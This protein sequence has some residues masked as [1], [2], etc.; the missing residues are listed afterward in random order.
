MLRNK[1]SEYKQ[2]LIYKLETMEQTNPKE[3]WKILEELKGDRKGEGNEQIKQISPGQWAKLYENLAAPNNTHGI[4]QNIEELE[5]ATSAHP[6]LDQPVTI[7]EVKRTLRNLKNN[8]A[9]ANDSILNEMIKTAADLIAPRSQR[10]S[11]QSSPRA[12]S[13][14]HGTSPIKYLC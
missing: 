5:A 3:F 12:T 4:T 11:T 8:K 13:H 14:Q 6:A 10:C 9:S 2:H 7:R 1:A